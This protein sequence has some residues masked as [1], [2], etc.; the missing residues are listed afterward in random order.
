MNAPPS[1]AVPDED[2][3]RRVQAGEVAAFEPLVARHE[4]G[5]HT[6]AR[7]I[8]RHDEDA[9]DVTQETFLRAFEKIDSFDPARPFR[10]WLLR[11]AVHAALNRRRRAPMASLDDD[12]GEVPVLAAPAGH[13][14]RRVVEARMTVERLE[15]ELAALDPLLQAL[16]DLRYR[17][18]MELKEIAAILGKTP[19]HLAVL[20]HRTRH[21]LRKA[22]FPEDES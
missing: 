20:L 19:N 9:L 15:R 4:R 8:L 6:L 7:R 1:T 16:F 13:S 2:L 10:P 11:I 17:E 5:V 12:S 3:A 14:P 18:Q 22:L 21:R